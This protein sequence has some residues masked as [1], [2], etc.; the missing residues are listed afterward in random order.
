MATALAAHPYQRDALA[1][2]DTAWAKG[3]QR[4]L[5]VMPTGTGKTFTFTLQVL[6]AATNGQRVLV[7]VDAEELIEQTVKSFRAVMTGIHVGVVKAGRNHALAQVIV[8]SIQTLKIAKRREAIGRF[9]LIVID[10]A[11]MAAAQSY[12]DTVRDLGGYTDSKVRVIG[13]TATADR[14]GDLGL[15][16]I[17]ETVAYQLPVEWAF[18]HGYLVRPKIREMKMASKDP[19]AVAARWK[20]EVGTEQGVIFT[21]SVRRAHALVAAL[22]RVG[23]SAA[24]VYDKTPK[25]E[26]ERLY[27][28]IIDGS[29]RVLVNVNVLVKGFD[30]PRLTVAGIDRPMTQ[31]PY[32]QSVGRALRTFKGD[33]YAPAKD[34]ATV[35]LFEGKGHDLQVMPNLAPTLAGK[36]EAAKNTQRT[37]TPKVSYKIHIRKP[38]WGRKHAVVERVTQTGVTV[39]T[40][41]YGHPETELIA[42]ARLAIQTDQQAR[43]AALRTQIREMTAA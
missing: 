2:A 24:V 20:A 14:T 22:Q 21:S 16:D 38:T 36:R 5:T 4:I 6:E 23:L 12:I 26:R 37:A 7:I 11:H 15:G 35:L 31:V 28:R 29:L 3:Y 32:V 30:S 40:K 42:M 13:Y 39:V 43:I 1:A 19:Q 41:I 9:G 8:A 25:A 33:A 10:E 18:Q 34:H 17:W 27:D